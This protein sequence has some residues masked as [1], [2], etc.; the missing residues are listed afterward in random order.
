MLLGCSL[1]GSWI[2]F[3]VLPEATFGL[4]EATFDL[5]KSPSNPHFR[6]HEEHAHRAKEP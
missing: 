5:P 2:G 6:G 4:P 3:Q 1:K